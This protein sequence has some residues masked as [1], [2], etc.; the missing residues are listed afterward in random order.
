VSTL[1]ERMCF[2]YHRECARL[3]DSVEQPVFHKLPDKG[4]AWFAVANAQERIL[5]DP[6]TE[7]PF[8]YELVHPIEVWRD[9]S[10]DIVAEQI[11][12][13]VRIRPIVTGDLRVPPRE[14]A[15]DYNAAVLAQVLGIEFGMFQWRMNAADAQAIG[16][17]VRNATGLDA[18]EILEAT[19][20]QAGG[21]PALDDDGLAWVAVAREMLVTEQEGFALVRC[22]TPGVGTLRVGPLRNGHLTLHSKVAATRG[23]WAGRIAA[24]TKACAGAADGANE[25]PV[26]TIEHLRAE[27]SGM[28]WDAFEEQKK[29][30]RVE[31][32]SHF[33]RARS[34]RSTGGIPS[35]STS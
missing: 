33:G 6:K 15:E 4:A 1:A 13:S 7:D 22:R 31:G 24:L 8:D 3:D 2:A 29:K 23:E 11:P 20:L 12:T 35:S 19:F 34:T 30:L 14:A 27:D 18:C 17:L 32:T 26:S 16:M 10:G 25:T 9:K 28:L 5:A 21:V